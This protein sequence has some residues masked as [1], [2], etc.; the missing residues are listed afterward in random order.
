M[1]GTPIFNVKISRGTPDELN[2]FKKNLVVELIRL[3]SL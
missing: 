3:D 1:I 2:A